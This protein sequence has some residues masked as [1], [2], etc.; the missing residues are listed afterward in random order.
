MHLFKWRCQPGLRSQS[1]TGTIVTQRIEIED[2]L[3]QSPSLK[4]KLPDQLADHYPKAVRR[5]A[6]DTGL[7][8]DTFALECPFTVEQILHPEYLP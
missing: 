3:E 7:P 1:G 6:G 5:A 2:E 8:T 4:R